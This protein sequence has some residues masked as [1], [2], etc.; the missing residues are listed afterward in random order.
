MKSK[1]LRELLNKY[2]GTLILMLIIAVAVILIG[3]AETEIGRRIINLI[4]APASDGGRGQ[5]RLLIYC[6]YLLAAAIAGGA[7]QYGSIVIF[8]RFNRAFVSDLRVKLFNHLLQSPQDF[9]NKNPM[10]QIINRIMNEAGA[11][12]G[13]FAKV[14]MQP[15][16]KIFMTIFYSV[17]LFKLNWR[18]A[19]AGILFIPLYIIIVPKINR[20]MEK[21][22]AESIDSYGNLT[23]HF[24][25]VFNGVADIRAGQTYFFEESRLKNKI[26]EYIDKN[27]K[28]D[29]AGG[30]SDSLIKTIMLIA[31]LSLYLY[32]GSLC[33]KG[34][35]AVGTLVASIAIVNI[36]YNQIVAIISII[37]EWRQVRVRLEKLDEYFQSESENGIFPSDECRSVSGGDIQFDKVQFGFTA[38]QI[39]L[40]DINFIAES[41]KKVA[42]VGPSGSGK[43]LTAV[44]LG[45]IYK[46]LSGNITIG[47]IKTDAGSLYD[48][49]T[50]IGYVNQTPFLFNDT[51]RNNILYALLRKP[52]G[53]EDHIETWVDFSLFDNIEGMETLEQRIL[54][55]VKDV[56]LFED[57]VNIGLRSRLES[58]AGEITASD[59]NAIV[60]ARNELGKEIAQ[61]HSEYVEFFREDRF[62]EYCTIFE[63]IVFCPAAAI[64]EKFG[65][66]RRFTKDHLHDALQGKGLMESLFNVGLKLVR[67][68]DVL[69][70]KLYKDK[71]PLLDYM[72]FDQKQIESRKKISE[73]LALGGDACARIEKTDPAL[74]EE[75]IEL[76]FNHCPGK[77]KERV[78]EEK[79]RNEILGLRRDIKRLLLEKSIGDIDYYDG[80]AFNKSLSLMENIVFGNIDPMRK[81]A[82]EEIYAL[83]RKL[84]QDAGLEKLVIKRGLEF[85]VGERGVKL[86]GGQRQK[87][88]IARILL[89]NPAI[90]ILDEATASLDAGSQARING[91]VAEKFKDKTVISIAHRLNVIKDYDEILVFDK[92]RIVEQGTF[93]D[94]IKLNGLF[95]NLIQGSN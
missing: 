50:K 86:S 29:K 19:I 62:L 64:I 10:E 90:L 2:K 41:G 33:L 57:V 93:K 79:M 45:T 69:L 77:S 81:R 58:K 71:S 40:N 55:I 70:D 28:M 51:I 46:P 24:Q 1:I 34:D 37:L 66:L 78:L 18:L 23:G 61:H 26:R 36:L 25:E 67:A 9:F 53:D 52:A 91:L 85:A 44:L 72:E 74:V 31:P 8:S 22:T 11:I 54:D 49:R 17:Y 82:N 65:S 7:G 32:G 6:L 42:F 13:F 80:R 73:R 21:L 92:G 76:A 15:M 63:N 88:I 12:G 38:D 60:Q 14:F 48:L 27:L 16:I 68:N 20:R 59:K 94:L 75:I 30:G 89:K 84:V 3:I 35:L 47:G 4:S 95:H 56:G 39:L 5:Q 43:S 83:V 87:V